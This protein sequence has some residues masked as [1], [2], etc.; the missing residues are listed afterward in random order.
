MS[1]AETFLAKIQAFL[2]ESGM[3]QTVFGLRAVAD[4]NF[5]SDLVNGRMPSLR[6]VDKVDD[7]I[8]AYRPGNAAQPA[9]NGSHGQPEAHIPEAAE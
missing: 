8:K 9:G 4:G 5:V 7:F 3:T 1:S 2:S 6:L